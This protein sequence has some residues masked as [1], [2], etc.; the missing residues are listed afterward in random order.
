[1]AQR[2]QGGGCIFTKVR[3]GGRL[4]AK[5][6]KLSCSGSILGVLCKMVV[7]GGAGRCG[8]GKMAGRWQVGCTFNNARPRGRIWVNTLKPS[9]CGSVMDVPCKMP[10]GSGAG[11]WWV[12]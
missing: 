3:F 8:C 12:Q 6:L 5:N 2:W 7:G 9:N 11:T 4:Q 1:M 10:V